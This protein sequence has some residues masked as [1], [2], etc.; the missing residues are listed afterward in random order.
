ML[1]PLF[2][3]VLGLSAAPAVTFSVSPD[4][5]ARNIPIVAVP[6][7]GGFMRAIVDTGGFTESK[8]HHP[9]DFV[10]YYHGLPISM[11]IGPDYLRDR[12]VT[13]GTPSGGAPET[14]PLDVM[15]K[16]GSTSALLSCNI[17][18]Q[19]YRMLLDT[20]ALAWSK[21][22]TARASPVGV[23]FLAGPAFTDV[24]ARHPDWQTQE[25]QIAGEDRFVTARS[26]IAPETA[27]GGVVRRNRLIVE[28]SDP[29]TFAYLAKSFG[30]AVQGD[31]SLSAFSGKSIRL[32]FP[33][34]SLQVW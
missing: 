26:M 21:S 7:P 34:R 11:A 2:I 16:N 24:L 29:T 14:I 6:S 8:A 19:P 20:A 22:D 17:G 18:G 1:R 23:I 30:V 12:S 10:T 9:R 5:W 13:L 31:A 28:R 27:C 25:H 32:D 3:A 15:T 4:Q 33:N